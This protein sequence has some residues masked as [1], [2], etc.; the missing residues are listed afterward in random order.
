MP[1]VAVE[2]APVLTA[3]TVQFSAITIALF[4]LAV[5]LLSYRK[6]NNA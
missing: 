3:G 1:L 2:G 6:K 5:S 4:A